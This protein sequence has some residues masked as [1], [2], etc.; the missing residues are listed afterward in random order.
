MLL[1]NAAESV[2]MIQ[3]DSAEQMDVL[4]LSK[5]LCQLGDLA[6]ALGEYHKAR[7]TYEQAYQLLAHNTNVRNMNPAHLPPEI[8]PPAQLPPEIIP[9]WDQLARVQYGLGI[10]NELLGLWRQAESAHQQA[11]K[12]LDL[13]A[14]LKNLDTDAALLRA[15][16]LL[17]LATVTIELHGIEQAQPYALRVSETWLELL[18]KAPQSRHYVA[19]FAKAQVNLAILLRRLGKHPQSEKAH[20]IAIQLL[21]GLMADYPEIPLYQHQLARAC[22]NFALF[23]LDR[24][25]AQSQYYLRL[26]ICLEQDLVTRYPN[27]EAY[28]RLLR[29]ATHLL[30]KSPAHQ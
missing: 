21:S 25:D 11:L 17:H 2:A 27:V 6:L 23:H 12:Y 4:S 19:S 3:A 16:V 22:I 29:E 15:E 30:D 14:E 26:A 28:T 9:R 8:I 20:K 1:N 24:G 13:L 5:T 18:N 10:V 7:D